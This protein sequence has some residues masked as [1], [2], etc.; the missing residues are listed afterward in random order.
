[1]QTVQNVDVVWSIDRVSIKENGRSTT[2]RCFMRSN[3]IT[4]SKAS[5]S[6]VIGSDAVFQPRRLQ[7]DSRSSPLDISPPGEVVLLFYML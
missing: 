2:L 7:S 6:R 5:Y 1:M 4:S 3:A